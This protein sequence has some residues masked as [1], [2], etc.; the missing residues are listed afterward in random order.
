[1]K[2]LNAMPCFVG[3]DV[4][5][6][7]LD[8]CILPQKERFQVENGHFQ[9]LCQRLKKVNPVLIVLEASG[10]Y[11]DG[12]YRALSKTGFKVSRENPVNIF[13]HRQSRGKKAKTDR[14]DAE[15][16]AHYAQCH[17][18]TIQADKPQALEQEQLRQLLD[19]RADLVKMQTAEKNRLKA[20]MTE[21]AIKSSIRRTLAFL[22]KEIDK[23]EKSIQQAVNQQECLQQKQECLITVPGVGKTIAQTLLAWLPELGVYSHKQLAAL[24]G[25]APFHHE[26]GQYQGKRRIQG[27]RAPVRS[28]LY[29]AALSA[30]RWNPIFQAYYQQLLQKGKAKKVA[31]IACAHKLLRV[32]N[33]MMR[34][35]VAFKSA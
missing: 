35:Q 30:V 11:E 24:V 19:R 26:S 25:L 14:I 15:T 2:A 9:K 23:V 12:V 8:I 6:Q 22:E 29:L 13:H 34:Q 20:P 16:I 31:L 33:A 32:M 17:A 7:T 10:G 4:S 1:M 5:K 18:E 21:T 27:G 28:V 3:I